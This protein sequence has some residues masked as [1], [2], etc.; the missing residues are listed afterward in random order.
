MCV[1]VCVCVCVCLLCVCVCVCVVVK[2]QNRCWF[3]LDEDSQVKKK[4]TSIIYLKCSIFC[5]LIL[6]LIY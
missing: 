2:A 3:E 6:Y 1:C 4:Y 5:A